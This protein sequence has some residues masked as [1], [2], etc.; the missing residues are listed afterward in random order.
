LKVPPP[1]GVDNLLGCVESEDSPFSFS[2][3]SGNR[4]AFPGESM[5]FF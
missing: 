4:L 1:S 5:D 3:T 2:S